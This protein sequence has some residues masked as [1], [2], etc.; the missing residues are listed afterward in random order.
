MHYKIKGMEIRSEN[1]AK[2]VAD[3]A[4]PLVSWLSCREFTPLA[5]DF[6]C[7]KLRYT[8]HLAKKSEC[9]GVVDSE[10]QLT[11]LQFIDGKYTSVRN[12]IERKW[13]QCRIHKLEDVWK[14]PLHNYNFVLCANVL[15]AIPC[16][17]AR[18][19]SLRSIHSALSE[20]GRVLFVSQHTNSYFT[21]AQRKPNAC[22]HLNGWIIGSKTVPSYYGVLNRDS[23]I[24]LITRYGFSIVDAWIEGQSNYVLASKDG[25]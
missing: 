1:S 15:S 5:L 4:A 7:G 6:G 9:L 12:Y 25:R 16:P 23:V 24:R 3:A 21:M 17:K 20:K 8:H 10:V 18:A 13:P 22:L 14:N 11:R 2:P 19:R